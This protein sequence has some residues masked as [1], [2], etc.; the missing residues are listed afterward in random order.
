MGRQVCQSLVSLGF[1]LVVLGIS[2]PAWANRCEQP[3]QT[4][5]PTS[6]TRIFSSPQLGFSFEIPAN[7]RAMGRIDGGTEFL[8]PATFDWRQC[9]IRNRI[10]TELPPR[11]MIEIRAVF[12]SRS[13]S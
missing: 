2:M 11:V 7:Y 1:G 9:V 6:E 13:G 10:S 12:F 5:P 8:D 4:T 3:Q